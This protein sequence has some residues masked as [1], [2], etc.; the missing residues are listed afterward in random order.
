MHD[1]LCDLPFI[2]IDP[3]NIIPYAKYE[4]ARVQYMFSTW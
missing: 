3:Y 4:Y 2:Y 1:I